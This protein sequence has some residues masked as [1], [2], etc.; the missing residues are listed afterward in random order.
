MLYR[1]VFLTNLFESCSLNPGCQALCKCLFPSKRG[2]GALLENDQIAL[3]KQLHIQGIPTSQFPLWLPR[4]AAGNLPL[5]EALLHCVNANEL[6]VFVDYIVYRRKEGILDTC[7]SVVGLPSTLY[8][9]LPKQ[10][11]RLGSAVTRPVSASLG[12]KALM[13]TFILLR[14]PLSSPSS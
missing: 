7:S 8:A 9:L 10:G 2:R 11:S 5:D 14:G 6:P 4:C 3:A 12:R 1:Q 13:K